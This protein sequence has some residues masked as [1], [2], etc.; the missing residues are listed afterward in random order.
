MEMKKV[1]IKQLKPGQEVA[2]PNCVETA[3]VVRRDA[4]NLYTLTWKGHEIQMPRSQIA[5]M[6]LGRWVTGPYNAI[7]A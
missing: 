2:I 6:Y 4:K 5:V 1:I 3:R 7:S